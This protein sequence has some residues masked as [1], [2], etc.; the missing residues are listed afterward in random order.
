MVKEP[1][2]RKIDEDKKPVA[3][4]VRRRNKKNKPTNP[5]KVEGNTKEITFSQL[6]IGEVFLWKDGR[7]KKPLNSDAFV[8]YG[9]Y[10]YL[11][12]QCY[13]YIKKEEITE[14]VVINEK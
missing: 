3:V 13:S 5:K 2:E 1:E 4:P 10:S 6:K 8:K 9:I 7:K 12:G 11:D 14:S